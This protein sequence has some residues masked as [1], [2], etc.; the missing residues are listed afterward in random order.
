MFLN[1]LNAY[2]LTEAGG[3]LAMPPESQK[4]CRK[5]HRTLPKKY[6]GESESL[7]K[8]CSNKKDLSALYFGNLNT[9]ESHPISP[10]N[11]IC[12]FIYPR[13]V[14]CSRKIDSFLANLK[15]CLKGSKSRRVKNFLKSYAELPSE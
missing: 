9:G 3:E 12:A 7:K 1:N 10:S 6:T 8:K 5:D 2:N 14:Q 15:D 11:E 13:L 4:K